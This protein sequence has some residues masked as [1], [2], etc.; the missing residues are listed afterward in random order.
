MLRGFAV[1]GEEKI[2]MRDINA[3]GRDIGAFPLGSEVGQNRENAI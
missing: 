3:V 1:S 2:N